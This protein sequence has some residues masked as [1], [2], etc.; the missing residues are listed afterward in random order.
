MC[1]VLVAG[2]PKKEQ[3]NLTHVN[4]FCQKNGIYSKYQY[5]RQRKGTGQI[6]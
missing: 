2:T 4:Y 3:L 6:D 1:V 5:S